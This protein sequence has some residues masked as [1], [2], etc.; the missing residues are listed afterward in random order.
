MWTS[1]V[2]EKI[3]HRTQLV[4]I[5]LSNRWRVFLDRVNRFFDVAEFGNFKYAT[6]LKTPFP[7]RLETFLSRLVFSS[8]VD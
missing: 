1:L 3:S 8:D 5:T 4:N 6:M 2:T 7:G